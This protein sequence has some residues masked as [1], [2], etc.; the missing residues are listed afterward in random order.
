MRVLQDTGL[1]FEECIGCTE[2][3]DEKDYCAHPGLRCR[4]K[5]D[6]RLSEELRTL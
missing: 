6:S 4:A 3:L 1:K 5:A 2:T